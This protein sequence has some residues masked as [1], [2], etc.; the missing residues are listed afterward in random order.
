MTVTSLFKRPSTA[1]PKRGNPTKTSENHEPQRRHADC[2]QRY[3]VGDQREPARSAV[4]TGLDNIAMMGE[5]C[6]IS[7]PSPSIFANDDGPLRG[8]F[9]DT[10]LQP[11]ERLYTAN[12]HIIACHRQQFEERE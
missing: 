11:F 12:R 4:V 10:F 2:D 5:T 3:G 1:A 8:A 6:S 9:A 7:Q